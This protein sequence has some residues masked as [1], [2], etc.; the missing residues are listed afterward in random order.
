MAGDPSEQDVPRSVMIVFV[1][2]LFDTANEN[3]KREKSANE[4]IDNSGCLG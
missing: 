1:N 4:N 3:G 2:K